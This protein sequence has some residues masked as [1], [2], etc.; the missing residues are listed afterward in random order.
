MKLQAITLIL[1]SLLLA[2]CESE[3]EK[4]ARE[5]KEMCGYQ[6]KHGISHAMKCAHI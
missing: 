4:L 1:F 5:R 3:A 6:W 2:G